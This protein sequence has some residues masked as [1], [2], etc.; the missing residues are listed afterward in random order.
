MF[1]MFNIFH[2]LEAGVERNH[3]MESEKFKKK[4]GH[5]ADKVTMYEKKEKL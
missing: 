5:Y 3:I 1:Y 2:K 4:K